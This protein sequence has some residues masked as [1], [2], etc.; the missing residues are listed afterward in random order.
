FWQVDQQGRQLP[1]IDQVSYSISQD[2]ESL[3]L[4]I[5]GG[6]IDM[7]DRHIN[8]LANKPTLSQNIKRGDY[9]LVELVAANAQQVQI[10]LNI[11][12]KDP[13]VREMLGNKEFRRALSLGINRQE[14]IELVYL[15][16]SEPYQTS[17]RPG[18]PWHHAKL[19]KQFTEFDAPQ[20]KAILDKL[21][22]DKKDGQGFRLRPDGQKSLLRD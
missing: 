11:L 13:K 2:V 1:Y 8:S 21:G 9:H 3:M 5:V 20:A 19:A 4:D 7:Q 16:Q 14:I 6:K 12:H 15:G 17:P 10:Y 22:Y 18:H